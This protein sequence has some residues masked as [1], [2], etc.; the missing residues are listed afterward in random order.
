MLIKLMVD[1]V[2]FDVLDRYWRHQ[3]NWQDGS[4]RLQTAIRREVVGIMAV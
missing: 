4:L 1:E 3:A 2:W